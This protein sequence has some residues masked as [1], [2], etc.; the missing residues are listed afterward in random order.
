[1]KTETIRL[2]RNLGG[3]KFEDVTEKAGVGDKGEAALVWKLGSTFVDVNND[4]LLDIYVCRFN[5]PNLLYVNQGDGTFK[6]MAHAY[7]WDI[8]AVEGRFERL[9]ENRNREID[10]LNGIYQTNLD[11]QKVTTL[12]G[13]AVITGAHSVEVDG[14]TVTFDKLL[15]ATGARPMIPNVPGAEHGIIELKL[16]TGVKR[17]L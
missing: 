12:H 1:M 7:G 2:F 8:G 5:A 9:L 13:R 3:W 6:E 16:K 14:K 11:N 15:I 10:R 4:G 17:L